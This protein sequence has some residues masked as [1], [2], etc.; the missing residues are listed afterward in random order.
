MSGSLKGK[1]PE[2]F[3]GDQ[4]KLK[5]FLSELCIYFQL[6]RKKL[7]IKNCYSRVLLALS[8]IKGAN[9]VNWINAQFDEVEEDLHNLYRGD[10]EDEDLWQDFLKRFKRV[11]VS[12]T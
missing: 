2:N 12:T 7:D 10:K 11:Y 4:T 6:N 5:E 9:V 1:A 8:F 3:N